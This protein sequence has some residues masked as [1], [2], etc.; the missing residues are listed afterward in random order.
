MTTKIEWVAMRVLCTMIILSS[1]SAAHA[2]GPTEGWVLLPKT[3]TALGVDDPRFLGDVAVSVVLPESIGEGPGWENWTMDEM[4]NVYSKIHSAMQWWAAREPRANLRF[5]YHWYWRIPTVY[6]P[7]TVPI[8]DSS[9][10]V[11]DVMK[12][13]GYD[14]LDDMAAVQAFN[15]DLKTKFDAD[16]AVTIFVVDSSSDG[17]ESFPEGYMFAHECGPYL[18]VTYGADGFGIGYLDMAVSAGIGALFCA[19]PQFEAAQVPCT[20]T[21]GYYD[22]ETQNSE[23]GNCLLDEPSIMKYQWEAWD[24]GL[25]DEYARGQLGWRFSVERI[26]LP[27]MM[28]GF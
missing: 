24:G 23:F 13:L 20:R 7:V 11:L 4:A 26:Y 10:W 3:T 5:S 8:S 25:V 2:Q 21:S 27:I 17:D 19:L 6:E 28:K 16:Y 18:G 9:L 22:V 12:Y 15:E 1:V 14:Y